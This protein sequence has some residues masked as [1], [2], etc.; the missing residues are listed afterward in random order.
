MRSSADFQGILSPVHHEGQRT[1]DVGGFGGIR[2]VELRAEDRG[3]REPAPRLDLQFAQPGEL[4][5]EPRVREDDGG[6][7]TAARGKHPVF[8]AP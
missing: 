2:R 4:V 3:R 7:L 8:Q 1:G 6:G 5:A